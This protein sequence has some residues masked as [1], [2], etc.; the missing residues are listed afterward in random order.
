[1]PGVSLSLLTVDD[2]RLG[3][4]D[5][6]TAA[7]AWP[8]P[9]VGGTIDIHRARLPAGPNREAQDANLHADGRAHAAAFGA[10]IAAVVATLRA[11]EANL[12]SWIASWVTGISASA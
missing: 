9:A 8:A 3:L 5:A 4:L 7:P 10:A 12:T 2:E 11:S 6:P 1:M